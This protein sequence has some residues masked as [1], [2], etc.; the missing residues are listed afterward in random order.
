MWINNLLSSSPKVFLLLTMTL[1]ALIVGCKG[2][3]EVEMHWSAHSIQVDGRMTDWTA[4]PTMFF[5]ERAVQLGL[6]NDSEKL[7][8]LFRFGNE[9]W[10]RFIRMGGL[11][12]WV[13]NSG[14]KKKAFGLRYTGGPPLPEGQ[15]QG[16]GGEGGFLDRL[17]EEQKERLRQREIK[18]DQITV[19]TKDSDSIDTLPIDGSRGP[20]VSFADLQ[21]IYTYEFSIPLQK[22]DPTTYG[23]D[24]QPGQ[25]L[26]LGLEWGLSD[27]DRKRMM[28]EMRG[29]G[30]RGGMGG[31]R[32]GGV[33][34]GMGGGWGGMGNMPRPQMPGKHE[35]WV[36]TVL[37]SPS[38]GQGERDAKDL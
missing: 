36:K 12:L 18:T 1:P 7:H 26:G 2:Q 30:M 27:E 15:G 17:T 20:A 13:D 32:P 11:T 10:A 19:V 9:M 22:S 3:Q 16:M 14:E 33:R 21:G 37:A 25:A 23:I 35:I 34:G 6:A 5:E 28:E 24:A 31:G 4:I 38:N 29:G 8:I